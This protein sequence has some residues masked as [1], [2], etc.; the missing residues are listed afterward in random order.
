MR[1][2]LSW[3]S[4]TQPSPN[5]SRYLCVCVCMCAREHA[6]VCECVWCVCVGE[7]E[8][9][10]CMCLCVCVRERER[11]RERESGLWAHMCVCKK[12]RDGE[13]VCV[14]VRERERESVCVHGY[15]YMHVCAVPLCVCEGGG[16][17]GAHMHTCACVSRHACMYVDVCDR[18]APVKM[19][20]SSWRTVWTGWLQ[21]LLT[22]S[23]I[24]PE[25]FS[26]VYYRHANKVPPQ[27]GDF[28]ICWDLFFLS[29]NFRLGKN[30]TVASQTQPMKPKTTWGSSTLWRSSVTRST[31]VTRYVGQMHL[32]AI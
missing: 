19:K 22:T 21:M 32:C 28:L 24:P 7:R 18:L 30:W 31:T 9:V 10:V 27:I 23:L 17:G 5:W 8:C 25:V 3:E 26:S 16:W 15:S 11:E 29:P 2:R 13:C 4:C 12:K 20:W 14:C 1:S 6:C